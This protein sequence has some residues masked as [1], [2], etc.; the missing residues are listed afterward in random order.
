MTAVTTA[1][2]ARTRPP[3]SGPV[4][5]PARP[6][7]RTWEWAGLLYLA[8]AMAVY[9]AFTVRPIVETVWMSFFEWDGLT[10]ATWVGTA[11]YVDVLT[12]PLVRTAL[13]HSL[14][15]VVFYALLPTAVGLVL[16]GI[17]SRIR[18]RGMTA[19][20]TMLFL[21]QVLSS[22]VVAVAWRWIYDDT[23]PLNGVLRAIGLDALT[24]AWLGDYATALP[25]VGFIGTWVQF[26]L[27]LMLFLA[28]AQRIPPELYEAARIDGAGAVREFFTVTVPGLRNEVRIALVLTII[29]ALRNFDIVWN[30]TSGGPGTSTTVPSVYVYQ[31]AFVTREVGAAA[32]VAVLLTAFILAVAGLVLRVLRERKG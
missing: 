11:N 15:F 31:G 17:M 4:R 16:A 10:L 1:A 25:A 14:A 13:G 26:G 6:R 32:A 5:A 18:I 23:G 28:G 19:W 8:P 9:T 27:C 30:T 22:V 29:F 3:G 21:P 24:T 7:W 12:D 2:A 20:R